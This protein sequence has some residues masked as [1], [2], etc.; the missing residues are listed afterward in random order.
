MTDGLARFLEALTFSAG[1]NTALVALGA[2]LLGMAAGASGAFLFLRKRA[3]VSDAVS[4]ATLPG[5]GFAF[6][7]MVA[8]GGDGRFLPGLMI[9][10]ALSAGL[11]LVIVEWMARA[12]RLSEDAAIGAVLSVF[13]GLGIVLLTV[14][15][16]LGA[17]KAAGLEDFLLG[18]TAGMLASEAV[19]IAVAGALSGLAIFA[20]RRPMTLVAF[21]PA[22]A[23]ASGVNVRTIDLAM[24]GLAL[25]VTVIGL[26]IVGLIL[27]VALLIIP[28]VTARF[29]T[30]RVDRLIPIAAVAGGVAAWIGVAISATA[31]DM[32]TGAVI[33]LVAF[34]GFALS[35][36]VLPVRGVLA[37]WAQH[38]RFEARVH[39][40]QGLLAM[41]RGEPVRDPL[42]LRIL[43]RG[44]LIRGD[45][46]A[47]LEGR[48]AAAR[49]QHDEARWAALRKA[50][51]SDPALERHDGLTDI[52]AV[53]TPDQV[54]E[55]D[56]R[57]GPAPTGGA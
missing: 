38:R 20:L 56:A 29:W 9:G 22:H 21:D 10:A 34:A 48:A 37:A 53:L 15:Q 50:S 39:R 42:T 28:A 1:Y 41:A 16:A 36:L 54:A 47:T 11:G 57:L 13:F 44:G 5:V 51:A 8:M 25:V 7:L 31:R 32:P 46:V 33:V 17:G 4:H 55:I 2:A 45:G 24:M 52:E 18:A 49:A 27:I 19:T 3:L 23:A 43:R 12:T 35:L 40:R 6:I 14:I 26:K 30:D